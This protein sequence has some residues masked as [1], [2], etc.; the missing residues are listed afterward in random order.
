MKAR[1][2]QRTEREKKRRCSSVDGPCFRLNSVR[3]TFYRKR[4]NETAGASSG[5][6]KE[7]AKTADASVDDSI[8]KTAGASVEYRSAKTGE[9]EKSAGESPER[10]K[11]AGE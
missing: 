1:A 6:L 11:S 3:L 7:S 9:I 5:W 4:E 10:E 8:A 2:K